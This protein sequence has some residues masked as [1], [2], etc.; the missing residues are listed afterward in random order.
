[1]LQSWRANCDIQVLVYESDPANPDIKEI[2]RVTDYIVAYQTKGNSTWLEERETTKHIVMEAKDMMGDT[3]DLKRVCKQVMNKA[4]TRRLISK[5]EASVLIGNLPFTL[6][7]EHMET[8]S[9]SR[10]TRITIDTKNTN[11]SKFID[12]YAK[13]EP[14]HQHLSLHQY[15]PIYREQ[16]KNRT[17]SIPHYVGVSGFP[18]FPVSEAYARHVLICYKPWEVYPN[19]KDWKTEFNKFIT[20]KECP[21]SAR[22]TYDRVMQRHFNG[23]KFVDPKATEADHSGNPITKEDEIALILAG[24]G[25]KNNQSINI[26]VFDRL[27]FG[28]DFSWDKPPKVR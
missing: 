14:K 22:L 5:Q 21:R 15:F 16:I 1:M 25:T 7:S 6:S 17:P 26:D 12:I 10:S 23:T 2:S 9:I 11:S 24:L 18:C 8:I 19:K 3:S 20:S 13:R 4:A 28:Y 27:D